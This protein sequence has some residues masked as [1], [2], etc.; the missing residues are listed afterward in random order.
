MT[1]IGLL[2]AADPSVGTVGG[3]DRSSA[4]YSW[5][6]NRARTA[7]FGAKV[8]GTPALG[9]WGGDA[10]TAIRPMAARCCKLLQY[11]RRQLIRYGGKPDLFIAG[12][13]FIDAMEKEM[14]A[15]GDLLQTGFKGT[16]D[17][18]MG[19]MEFGGQPILYDPTLTTGTVQARLLD[20]LVR[21]SSSKRWRTSGCTSTHPPGLQ[22][23]FIMN[24]SITTTCQLV[25]RQFNSSLVIDIK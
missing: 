8:T 6:R 4:A 19:D 22:N 13:A 12:S 9:A 10:V 20:R 23:Q 18:A 25:G 5:W 2:V 16:Q 1:G 14:R 21:T 17:G 11:E 7:A 3:L 15:N 24:R